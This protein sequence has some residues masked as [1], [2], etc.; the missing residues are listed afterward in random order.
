MRRAF[1]SSRRSATM[2]LALPP[3]ATISF[4]TAATLAASTSTTPTLAPSRAKRTAPARPM[5]EPAAVTIPILS[6]SRMA[7]LPCC[8]ATP[9]EEDA[10]GKSAMTTRFALR[11][12]PSA[13][14]EGGVSPGYGNGQERRVAAR[15][16]EQ[17][18]IDARHRPEARCRNA[19][20][21]THLPPRRPGRGE[22]RRGRCG[23][24]LQR[25]FPLHDDVSAAERRRGIVQQM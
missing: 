17:A 24:A 22:E 4:T 15:D 11:E 7:P 5:P 20:C 16:G 2:P 8:L 14:D 12:W 19:L 23:R 10:P 25:H 3:P 18:G 1:S 6:F 21:E 13:L 9:R